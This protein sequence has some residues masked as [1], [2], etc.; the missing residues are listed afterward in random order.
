MAR[1]SEVDW[2]GFDPGSYAETNYA[3]LRSDDHRLLTALRDFLCEMDLPADSRAIDMGSGS[4][5][6]PALAL[7]PHCASITLW[8]YAPSNVDW[9]RTQ[10]ASYS[11]TWDPYWDV[12][13]E[14]P[15]YRAL[16]QPRAALAARSQVVRGSVFHT[17]P[18]A[19]SVG[20]M[21]FVAESIS[22][23]PEEFDRAVHRFLAA[24]HPGSP[25]FAAFMEHSTGYS[26]AGRDFPAVAVGVGEIRESLRART[27]SAVVERLDIEGAPLRAGYQGMVLARGRTRAA[28]PTIT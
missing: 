12:L 8:E 14:H 5:L 1:N 16:P 15:T 28:G 26:V 22:T 7:L 6:Y 27:E 20:T 10:T 18:A 21:F 4:N 23:A 13:A 2:S 19:W 9:L 25:F 17:P 3:R 24:L 11:P